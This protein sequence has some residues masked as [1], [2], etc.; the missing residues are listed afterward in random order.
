MPEQ[1]RLATV[2]MCAV[3][4]AAVFGGAYALAHDGP[5][6]PAPAPAAPTAIQL[7]HHPIG[8]LRRVSALPALIVPPP[9]KPAATTTT[10]T[11]PVVED[12]SP[13]VPTPEVSTPAPTPSPQPTPTPTPQ[14]PPAKRPLTFDDSG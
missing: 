12:P 11:T 4:A 14:P 10:T 13:V 2:A 3:L 7:E 1:L 5:A 8:E 9:P 6:E